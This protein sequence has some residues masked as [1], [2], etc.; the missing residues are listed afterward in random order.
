[1]WKDKRNVNIT[2][3]LLPPLAVS[4]PS[5]SKGTVETE[6]ELTR[7]DDTVC[8]QKKK[9]KKKQALDASS[10][11]SGG[12]AVSMVRGIDT[13]V[14]ELPIGATTTTTTTTNTAAATA[15]GTTDAPSLAELEPEPENNMRWRWKGTG[16]LTRWFSSEWEVL[17][18]GADDDDDDD[19]EENGSG[20][21]GHRDRHGDGYSDARNY[22]VV[23]YFSKTLVTPTGIDILSR[24]PAGPTERTVRRIRE[25]L[26]EVPDEDVRRL[27]GLI[28]EV[29]NE[30][31]TED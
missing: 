10:G 5:G 31:E 15:A 6:L 20:D 17:G 4:N 18:F 16:V 8:Y 3:G 30:A 19:D 22:W 24:R 26:R 25:A 14:R 21:K 11:G 1:M 28:F 13:A 23:T 2:Y 7:L 12:G 9:T 27:E 29:E